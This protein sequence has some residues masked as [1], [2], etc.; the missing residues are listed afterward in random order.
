[1]DHN[2]DERDIFTDAVSHEA[3][4]PNSPAGKSFYRGQMYYFTSKAN[5]EIFDAD[6][7]LWI[8]SAHG[9]VNSSSIMPEDA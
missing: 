2:A 1:M 6:P 5:K 9:S 4:N 7:G 3:V 8:P